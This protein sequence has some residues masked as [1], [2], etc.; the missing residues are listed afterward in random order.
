VASRSQIRNG[1]QARQHQKDDRPRLIYVAD[2]RNV[3][4]EGIR[5]ENSPSF[6]LVLE[7]SEAVTVHHVKITAPAHSPNTDGIDPIN[8]RHVEITDN[9]I[10]VGDDMVAIK[11]SKPDAAHPDEAASDIRI[12]GNTLLNGRGICIGSGTS[13]GVARVQVD[14]NTFAG[15]MYGLRIKSLRGKGGQVRNVE[16]HNNRMQDVATPLV[17]TAYYEYRPLD[18]KVALAQVRP[19]GFVLGNQIWPGPDDP[20]QPYVQRETPDLADI[21]VDG[22]TATGADRAGIIVGLPE[23][24]FRVC[25]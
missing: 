16:L 17:I 23:S 1:C 9:V 21:T 25:G 4:F 13:G 2:S 14:N 7:N 18:L 6:H 5:I 10:S 20:A 15:S 8:S 22:L 3:R 12:S 19:G 11:S 24:R